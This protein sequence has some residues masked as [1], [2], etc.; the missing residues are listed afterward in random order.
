MPATNSGQK[1]QASSGIRL[2]L[3]GRLGPESVAGLDWNIQPVQPRFQNQPEAPLT[4]SRARPNGYVIPSKK[5]N[6]GFGGATVQTS[7]LIFPVFKQKGFLVNT[8]VSL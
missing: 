4:Y 5:T 7:W 8:E 2:R 1:W 6:L 3:P